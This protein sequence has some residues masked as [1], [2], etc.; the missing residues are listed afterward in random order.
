M[1][2]ENKDEITIYNVISKKKEVSRKAD[3]K[4]IMKAYYLAA[5][6]H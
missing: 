5:E 3:R 2:T 6:K 1:I 4:L